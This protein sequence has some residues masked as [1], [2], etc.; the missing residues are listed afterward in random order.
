[1]VILYIAT[2]IFLSYLGV[3]YPFSDVGGRFWVNIIFL[4]YLGLFYI[5]FLAM[6]A[7][8]VLGG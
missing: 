6:G 7:V 8:L 4:S 3:C 1:M 2:F 5:P